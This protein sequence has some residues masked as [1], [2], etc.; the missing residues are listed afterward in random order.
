MALKPSTL[1]KLN[2]DIYDK[3]IAKHA[4]ETIE[5]NFQSLK[6]FTML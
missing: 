2:K 1:I 3:V 4:S 6:N 5:K